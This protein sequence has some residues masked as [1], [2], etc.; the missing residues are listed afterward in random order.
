VDKFISLVFYQALEDLM[1]SQFGRV[2]SFI[3]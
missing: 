3:F 1:R 2:T